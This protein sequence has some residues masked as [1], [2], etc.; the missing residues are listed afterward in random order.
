MHLWCRRE[1]YWAQSAK[2]EPLLAIGGVVPHTIDPVPLP[3][4][5][6]AEAWQARD[7][8]CNIRVSGTWS[9][10]PPYNI[11]YTYIYNLLFLNYSLN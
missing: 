11:Q 7:R 2:R 3:R 5:G 10:L 6:G 1:R 8:Q 9:L 4:G